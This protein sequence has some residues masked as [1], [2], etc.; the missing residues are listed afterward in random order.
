[1]NEAGLT[2]SYTPDIENDK[3]TPSL[4]SLCKIAKALGVQPHRLPMDSKDRTDFD[5]YSKIIKICTALKIYL[6]EDI[7]KTIHQQFEI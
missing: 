3:K 4:K 1:M 7:D 5:K 6:N 2:L